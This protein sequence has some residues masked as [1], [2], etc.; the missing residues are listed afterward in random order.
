MKIVKKYSGDKW[1]KSF[2]S[3]NHLNTPIYFHLSESKSLRTL[4][5]SLKAGANSLYHAGIGN[6]SLNNFSHANSKRDS[7][8]FE[9]LYY[10]LQNKFENTYK[11][12]KPFRF[13]NNVKAVD[14]TTISLSMSL[15]KWAKFRSTKSGIKLHTEYNLDTES[16][17]TIIITNA[18]THDTKG[19]KKF[20][21]EKDTI[22]ILDRA[23]CDTKTL[24]S[25]VKNDAFYV[26]RLKSNFKYKIVKRNKVSKKQKEQGVKTDWIIKFANE[27]YYNYPKTLRLIRYVDKDTGK[28][29]LFITNITKLVAKTIADIYKKRWTVETFFKELKQNLKIGHFIGNNENAVRIQIWTALI[30]FMLYKWHQYLLRLK[31][32]FTEFISK[33]KIN[34]FKRLSLGKILTEAYYKDKMLKHQAKVMQG[35]L[36]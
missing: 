32:G 18:N 36:W 1:S 3:W 7:R 6:I 8:I 15:F 21:I 35:L 17:G 27:K 11:G 10:H 25:L 16:P 28:E 23:Y 5:S 19:I 26:T 24:Y 20:K 31:F 12:T 2:N 13:N 29:F 14:A 34:L 30:V 4:I 33:V 22:Y 9:D